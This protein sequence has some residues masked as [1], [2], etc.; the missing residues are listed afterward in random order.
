M[1]KKTTPAQEQAYKYLTLLPAGT[2][3]PIPVSETGGESYFESRMKLLGIEDPMRQSFA[4]PSKM[5]N[6]TKYHPIFEKTG[7][8][9]IVINYPSLHGD[10]E[11]FLNENREEKF[12]RLR[13]NPNKKRE[14]KYYQPAGSGIHIFFPI[15]ILDKF[16]EGKEIETL[17]VIEG[18]FKAQA[19]SMHGLDIVGIGGKDNFRDHEGDLHKDIISVIDK[20]KVKNLVLLLDADVMT[21]K[22]EPEEDPNADVSKRLF[23][24]YNTVKRFR[25]V[26][27]SRVR[28]VYFSHISERYLEDAKGLDDLFANENFTPENIIKDL[29]KLTLAKAFFSCINLSTETG[30]KLKGYFCLNIYRGVPNAFYA[31]FGDQLE[32][33]EFNF[34]G[35]R[36]QNIK[37]DSNNE[38]GLQMVKSADSFKFI[39]VGCDYFK[40]IK[41]PNTNKEGVLDEKRVPWKAA[42][43]TRDFV[44]G[45]GLK[46]FFHTIERY[47]SFC[48]VPDN[49]SDYAPIVNDCYNLYSKIDHEPEPGTWDNINGYLKHVFG[50]AKLISGHTNFDLAL[51][52]L[53]ILYLKPRQ[54]LPILC[55]VNKKKNTGK[56]TF[57]WLLKEIFQA[58]ATF[59]GNEEL[60]D[61]LNDDWADKL[62]VGIDEGFIDKKT[63]LERLKSMSTSNTIKLRGMYAGRTEIAFFAKF[64]LTSNDETNFVAI[65]DDEVRFWVNKVP[66]LTK[67]DPELLEKMIL[68]IPAFLDHLQT[69]AIVHPKRTR[70]W[71]DF[72]L[73]E[74]EALINVKQNSRSWLIKELRETMKEEFFKYRYHTLV[75]TIKE[76]II[77]LNGDNSSIKFRK[78]D[79]TTQLKEKYGYEN[80]NGRYSMPTTPELDAEGRIAHQAFV[81]RHGRYFEFRAEDFL[82]D[83]ELI[84]FSEYYKKHE[85]DDYRRAQRETLTGKEEEVMPF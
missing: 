30:N 58:N 64:V 22:F 28:D 17:Y 4:V 72:K 80:K 35:N 11:T 52:Y 70:H 33:Y 46:N 1:S 19:G 8:D 7:S 63:V 66:Q 44:Q 14:T 18:E 67:D 29:E 34:Q 60:K 84:E 47:D 55:L 25:E 77:L 42:E 16:A 59:I 65:D 76:L 15:T 62:I 9:D 79:I 49:T 56:S 20:C 3:D 43:I 24:F 74:T 37:E 45:K 39:R 71:F 61:H 13:F 78:D 23:G 31:R 36:Y 83:R 48:N 68:E 27:K 12:Y 53:S 38:G 10:Q 51:D 73:L 81:P 5:A 57:L 40:L 69:R 54:K 75:Y 21:I 2:E 50:E 85:I 32:D 82:N 26:A 6:H 41:V